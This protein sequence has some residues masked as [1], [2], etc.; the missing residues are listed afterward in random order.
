MT[1]MDAFR[2]LGFPRELDLDPEAVRT[3]F[4]EI[5]L[6]RHPDR[7]G[8]AVDY[9]EVVEAAAILGNNARRWSH[10][11]ELGGW[12]KGGKIVEMDDAIAAE[13]NRVGELLARA[14]DVVQAKPKAET[15]IAKAM[16][17]RKAMLLVGEVS[18][19][20]SEISAKENAILALGKDSISPSEAGTLSGQLAALARWTR[21]LREAVAMLAG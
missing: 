1:D 14:R 3:R 10:W 13:F 8:N 16:V 17:E 2:I 9:S 18:A 11:A 12:K 21:E 20:L 4:Q 7:G 6:T 19:K 15:A 5:S